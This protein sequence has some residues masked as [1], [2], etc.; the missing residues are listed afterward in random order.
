MT[1]SAK[2]F[3][4]AKAITSW[5]EA[6]RIMGDCGVVPAY[7]QDLIAEVF[8]AVGIQTAL[9]T[10]QD[11]SI[12]YIGVNPPEDT[13]VIYT[14]RALRAKDRT[15][16]EHAG[17]TDIRVE[18]RYSGQMTSTPQV[19]TQAPAPPYHLLGSGH[20]TCGSSVSIAN[21]SGSA[22]TLGCLVKNDRGEL[23]GLSN[24]HVFAG[25]NYADIGIP[26]IAP[27]QADIAAR[28]LDPFVIGHLHQALHVIDGNP[29]IVPCAD[30]IDAAIMKLSAADRISSMQRSY[31]DTPKAVIP[32]Q[33]GMMVE[34]VGRT[35]G[36]T[37]GK[38]TSF[39]FTPQGVR[40]NIVKIGSFKI[41]YFTN[42]FGIV[43][44]NDTRFSGPGD[45]GSLITTL[46]ADGERKAVG[47]VFAG[48][49]NLSFAVSLDT[50]LTKFGL[51]LVGGHNI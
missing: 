1:D 18:F 39:H 11:R 32:L 44:E 42:I 48:H 12:S 26:I 6:N 50:V 38:V 34:K 41:L 16:L 46:D 49:D 17:S 51:S 27:G 43:G 29:E 3:A 37:R 30:N 8:R 13:I 5:A 35:T 23:Y 36:R 22:G 45:S 25:N 40:A 47:L 2:I 24:N 15:A 20:Y 31:Y 9:H 28:N 19:P 7:D 33:A 10:L 14:T 4:V 21:E